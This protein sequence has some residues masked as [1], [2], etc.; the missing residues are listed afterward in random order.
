M[1]CCRDYSLGPRI[2]TGEHYALLRVVAWLAGAIPNTVAIEFGVG[3]GESTAI[4]AEQLPVTGFGSADG[5]PED[6]RPGYPR[7]SFAHP[8]PDIPN[9]TLI[10]G[11]F[12]DTLPNY[13]FGAL[14]IGL[15]HFD[16]DLHSST[17]TALAHV[18]PHLHPGCF[19]V[20]DEW[21]GYYGC[22]HHEQRAWRE[23]AEPNG[24]TWQ[25]IGHSFEAWAIRLT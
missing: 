24:I 25:V 6:W 10:E 18:G 17:A 23:Y 9:T 4:I 2:E 22:E 8:L 16:A 1:P 15:A 20:F 13:D 14:N 21:H 7:G 19:L 3:A 5:L 12:C 11:W